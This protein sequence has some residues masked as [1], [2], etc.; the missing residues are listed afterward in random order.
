[1][2]HRQSKATSYSVWYHVRLERHR[3]LDCSGLHVLEFL[4]VDNLLAIISFLLRISS[5]IWSTPSIFH[6]WSLRLA[7]TC[8][9]LIPPQDWAFLSLPLPHHTSHTSTTCLLTSYVPFL[10]S[11]LSSFCLY[12]TLRPLWWSPQNLSRLVKHIRLTVISPLPLVLSFLFTLSTTVL[13]SFLNIV[14][15]LWKI[16]FHKC[17]LW[18]IT[19]LNT[20]GQHESYA[21]TLCL[22]CF[23][24]KIHPHTGTMKEK[25]L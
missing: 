21:F 5:S 13:N 20:C 23:L 19:H 15:N 2:P 16:W 12:L 25:V 4:R 14:L 7:S 17:L 8:H 24:H 22:L 11:T 1:M 10:C 9:S 6:L 18:L 3:C